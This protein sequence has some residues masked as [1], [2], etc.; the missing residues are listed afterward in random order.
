VKSAWFQFKPSRFQAF[1]L[2]HKC[3]L[4]C[5]YVRGGPP[6]T[7]HA[8]AGFTVGPGQ[9]SHTVECPKEMVGRIIGRAVTHSRGVSDWLRATAPLLSQCIHLRLRRLELGLSLGGKK[10]GRGAQP[11]SETRQKVV[12]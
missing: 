12:V 8:A 7:A 2:S 10:R 4:V 1:A 3:Q 11:N 6:G 5:R 9:A